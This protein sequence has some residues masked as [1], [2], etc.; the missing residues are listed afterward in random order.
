VEAF[1]R[2]L[3]K[4]TLLGWNRMASVGCKYLRFHIIRQSFE[5]FWV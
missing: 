3:W 5:H 2:G 4:E 1:A